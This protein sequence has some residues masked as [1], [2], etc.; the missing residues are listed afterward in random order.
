MYIPIHN[1]SNGAARHQMHEEDLRIVHPVIQTGRY[2][3][4][5]I[6]V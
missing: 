6:I 1:R 2:H 3:R 5:D 4:E